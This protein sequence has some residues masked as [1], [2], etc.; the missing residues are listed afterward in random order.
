MTEIIVLDLDKLS[1]GI[2]A[3]TPGFAMVMQE[4]VAMCMALRGH[5]TGVLCELRNLEVVLDEVRIVW[6]ISYS[7]RI[8]QGLTPDEAAERA[9]EGI[10]ILSVMSRTKYTVFERATI[11]NGYDFW[12]SQSDRDEQFPFQHEAG[13]EAK[14]LSYARYPSQIVRMV[15]VGLDQIMESPNAD[16]PA[17]VVAT[18]FSR[19]VVYMVKYEPQSS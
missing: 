4:V 18:E 16:L 13:L 1:T 11:G 9:G 12:L 3:V 19:P 8:R 15:N 6:N 10:A 17:W 14:G 2:P 7:E 5:S